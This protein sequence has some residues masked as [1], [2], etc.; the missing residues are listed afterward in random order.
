MPDWNEIF[1][2]KGKVFVNPH[3]DMERLVKLFREKGVKRILDLG[4]GTG[5]HLLFFSKNGFELY[6]VDAAPKGLEIA[7]KWLEEENQCA[8]LLLHRIEENLPFEDNFFDAVVSIQ[9]IHHNFL[10]KIIMT[11][12]VIERILRKGGIIFITF[13]TLEL[14]KH[15]NEWDLLEVE[16]RTFIPQKGQEKGVPHH[17]FSKDEIKKLF[18][19]FKILEMYI[20]ETE[21]RAILGI[22]K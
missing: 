15:K 2:E 9:V 13:P 3:P 19:N 21:H 16:T 6:G 10:E 22:K 14:F 11:I 20:D 1:S 8:E 18:K 17:F 5:R 12:K 4:C 7:K